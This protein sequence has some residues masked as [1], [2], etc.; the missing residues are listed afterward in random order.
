M[1]RNSLIRS[2]EKYLKKYP[3]LKSSNIFPDLER[4]MR[5]ALNWYD[6]H[7]NNKNLNKFF[8]LSLFKDCGN[9]NIDINGVVGDLVLP[10]GKIN[11]LYKDLDLF[12]EKL[13]N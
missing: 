2:F 1:S 8:D 12:L 11:E 13:K 6:W 4:F 5:N 9:K 7:T 3:D 10:E